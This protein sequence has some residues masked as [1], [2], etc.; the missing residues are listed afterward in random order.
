MWSKIRHRSLSDVDVKPSVADTG[1]TCRL[2]NS[3][4]CWNSTWL[5]VGLECA[6]ERAAIHC[7]GGGAVILDTIAI[8]TS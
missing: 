8:L 6:W 4:E 7:A 3:P 5:S 1:K 2:F